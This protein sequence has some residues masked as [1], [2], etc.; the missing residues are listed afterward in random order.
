MAVFRFDIVKLEAH[1]YIY[2]DS[3]IFFC[4][5]FIY[6][7]NIDEKRLFIFFFEKSFLLKTAHS[8]SRMT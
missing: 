7:N 2:T 1:Y 5:F 4:L 3:N 8:R 6:Y